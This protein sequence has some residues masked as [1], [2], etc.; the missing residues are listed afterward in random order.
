MPVEAYTAYEQWTSNLY[1]RTDGAFA[2]D[3]QA[4]HVQQNLDPNG[5]CGNQKTLDLLHLRGVAGNSGRMR[6]AWCRTR[7][8][9]NPAYPADDY[10][11][12]K[13]SPGAGFVVFDPSQAGR[14]NP[15]IKPPAVPA[16]FPRRLSIQG[17]I[18]SG[19]QYPVPAY[20]QF[21]ST[22]TARA[23]GTTLGAL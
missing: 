10:S 16:T 19:R 15:V 9:H 18:S 7:A 1:W 8:S 14:S 20:D 22:G 21:E 17:P 11:L 12:P 13:G 4:F 5:V 3:P 6:K 23:P 2:T